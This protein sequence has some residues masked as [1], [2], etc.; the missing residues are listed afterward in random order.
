MCGSPFC[1]PFP[2]SQ[3]QRHS[4]AIKESLS[5]T[6]CAVDDQKLAVAPKYHCSNKPHRYDFC[7]GPPGPK[8]IEMA[9]TPLLHRKEVRIPMK[10]FVSLRS[11]DNPSIEIAPTIDISCNGARVVTRRSWQPNQQLSV[12]S[13]SRKL[14][15]RARVV[16][17]QPYT[18]NSFVI[19]IEMYYP[20]GDWTARD[21]T[22][23]T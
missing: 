3:P 11:S 9:D 14:Y 1:S 21:R 10:M 20:T 8:E 19:G 15:S 17:C 6:N 23:T 12:R 16:H 2:R 13:I 7:V 5:D 22:G 18:G 4:A